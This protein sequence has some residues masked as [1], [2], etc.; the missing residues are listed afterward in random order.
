[1]LHI[2]VNNDERFANRLGIQMNIDDLIDGID[3]LTLRLQ[4]TSGTVQL[5]GF[6]RS[7]AAMQRHTVRRI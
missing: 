4:T 7:Q 1:M 3:N 2:T 6:A 5:I